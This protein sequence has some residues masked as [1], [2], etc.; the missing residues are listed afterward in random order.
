MP[1]NPQSIFVD[2]FEIKRA[3]KTGSSLCGDIEIDFS[4]QLYGPRRERPFKE[5]LINS[6]SF[7]CVGKM[8][9]RRTVQIK[10]P[11]AGKAQ[12]PK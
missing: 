2:E 7:I 8:P 3:C 10:A 9:E 1:E 12:W 4:F 6:G 5:P 11:I